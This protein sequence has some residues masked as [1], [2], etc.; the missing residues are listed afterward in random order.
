MNGRDILNSYNDLYKEFD[1]AS[2]KDI[3]HFTEFVFDK[4]LDNICT[5]LQSGKSIKKFISLSNNYYA[6]KTRALMKLLDISGVR[7]LSAL[8]EA[9]R[10]KFDLMRKRVDMSEA[11][12]CPYCN[13][14]MEPHEGTSQMSTNRICTIWCA[15]CGEAYYYLA[16]EYY[17]KEL[18]LKEFEKKYP[19]IQDRIKFAKE[20]S[21]KIKKW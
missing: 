14:V 13:K 8:E 17:M 21:G 4:W 15:Y 7:N 2:E 9:I 6:K 5:H 20:N 19:K 11:D 12:K 1:G 3:K 10:N 18:S 16:Q